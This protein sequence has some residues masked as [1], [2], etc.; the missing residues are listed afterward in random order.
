[1]RVRG[2]TSVCIP[3]L[4]F[5]LS[6]DKDK[7][8]FKKN[9]ESGPWE[10]LN[11][12]DP[13]KAIVKSQTLFGLDQISLR[14]SQNDT[15]AAGDYQTGALT[16][17]FVSNWAV[18][19]AEKVNATTLR[20]ASV[21]RIGYAKVIWKLCQNDADKTCSKT[22]VQAYNLAENIDKSFFKMRWDDAK[23]TLFQHNK[24]CGFKSPP[25]FSVRCYD[26]AYLDGKKFDDKDPAQVDKATQLIAG[27]DGLMTK[28][29]ALTTSKEYDDLVDV[30]SAV[31]LVM[32]SSMVGHWDSAVG[33]FNNDFVYFNPTLKKWKFIIWD[34]DNTFGRHADSDLSLKIL[35]KEK[36]ALVDPLLTFPDLNDRFKTNFRDYMSLLHTDRNGGALNDKIIEAR[37]CYVGEL[38][39]DRPG[40][41]LSSLT[42]P[43]V[44]LDKLCSK[45]GIWST[46]D[47]RKKDFFFLSDAEKMDKSKADPLFDFRQNRYLKIQSDLK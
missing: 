44:L 33:N 13:V 37:D 11:Y 22:I 45:T 47:Q 34:L 38:N 25:S 28:L 27:T 14:R 17:E 15:S 16:R 46:Q 23:P 42:A 5:T 20:G 32:A 21:Y 8:V 36:R 41:G 24:G 39:N 40:Q 1:M 3:R 30:S 35:P 43:Q 18:S 6:F 7:E 2:N 9:S 4:Q 10:E 31:N 26:P 12:S 19:Q 29:N